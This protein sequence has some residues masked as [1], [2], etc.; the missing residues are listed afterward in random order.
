MTDV[1][2]AIGATDRLTITVLSSI[3]DGPGY[4][5]MLDAA[6]AKQGRLR[7]VVRGAE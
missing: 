5:D 2:V 6:L 4:Q 7:D 1:V 3:V